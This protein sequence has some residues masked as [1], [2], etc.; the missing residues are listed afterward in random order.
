MEVYEGFNEEPLVEG[1]RFYFL[2]ESLEEDSG[3]Y[4]V[5]LVASFDV[6]NL[7]DE[8]GFI[9]TIKENCKEAI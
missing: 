3:Y 9:E 8:V 1:E 5:K 7:P 6:N 2:Q 4:P